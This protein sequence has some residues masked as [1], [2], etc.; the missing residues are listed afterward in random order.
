MNTN[1]LIKSALIAAAAVIFSS[2]YYDPSYGGYGTSYGT[3]GISASFVSTSSASWFY[4]PAV[5]CYYDRRR[6]CYYDPYLSGYYPRGYTPRPISNCPH[7]YNWKG[8][9]HAPVPH[10][11]NGRTLNNHRDRV[12]QLQSRDYAWANQV[13]VRDDA[14]VGRWQSNQATAAANFRGNER[15]GQQ[16]VRNQTQQPVRTQGLQPS[17]NQAQQRVDPRQLQN[18]YRREAVT[19]GTRT[20]SQASAQ[21]VRGSSSQPPAQAQQSQQASRQRAAAAQSARQTN[22]RATQSSRSPQRSQ[23]SQNQ[24]VQQVRSRRPVN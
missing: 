1:R 19:A 20:R 4:D 11:V 8:R 13:R 6:S 3:T 10:G 2:C 18:Q 12:S 17:R 24:R 23:S 16:P 15:Q 9:G 7:P 22:L 14:N 5:R 21:P